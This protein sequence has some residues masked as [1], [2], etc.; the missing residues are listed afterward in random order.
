M[1]DEKFKK[2]F[3]LQTLLNDTDSI[4]VLYRI[5]KIAEDQDRSEKILGAIKARIAEITT[6]RIPESTVKEL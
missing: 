6:I 5:Q 1:L 3:S 2:F 4:A